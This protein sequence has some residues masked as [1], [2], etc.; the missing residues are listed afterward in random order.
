MLVKYED[1]P[2]DYVSPPN[3]NPW[4]ASNQDARSGW[5]RSDSNS[6]QD[7][8]LLSSNDED[9]KMLDTVVEVTLEETKQDMFEL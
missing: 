9:D 2:S 1:F 6:D 8:N 4:E 5:P 3:R 7:E